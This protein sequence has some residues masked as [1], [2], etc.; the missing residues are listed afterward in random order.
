MI[1]ISKSL[2]THFTR[3]P[4]KESIHVKYTLLGHNF[5]R[6]SQKKRLVH[7]YFVCVCGFAGPNKRLR[8]LRLSQPLGWL[9]TPS[10]SPNLNH[11]FGLAPSPIGKSRP[12][13]VLTPPLP[14]FF[15]ISSSKFSFVWV[16]FVVNVELSSR[17]LDRM[18]NNW[19]RGAW[20]VGLAWCFLFLCSF[21][22]TIVA[23]MLF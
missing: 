11:F 3:A 2:S 16:C 23:R 20:G 8:R 12:L 13:L 17:G 7:A 5:E 19:R 15:I 4:R 21:S 6:N 1:E 22:G 18:K 10:P 9:G 14:L